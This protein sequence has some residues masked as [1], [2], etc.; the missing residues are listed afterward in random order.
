M[1]H[2]GEIFLKCRRICTFFKFYVR[3]DGTKAPGILIVFQIADGGDIIKGQQDIK[4]DAGVG[5]NIF[6]HRS[7]SEIY[8]LIIES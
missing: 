4:L 8:K 5:R 2:V 6:T 3:N 1:H 7:H